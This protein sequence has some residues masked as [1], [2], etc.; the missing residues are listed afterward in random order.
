MFVQLNFFLELP[1]LLSSSSETL[2]DVVH[3][4]NS[5]SRNLHKSAIA[6]MARMS[7]PKTLCQIVNSHLVSSELIKCTGLNFTLGMHR[8]KIT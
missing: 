7:F 2:V 4:C 5:C 8:H 3:R 6:V 1:I